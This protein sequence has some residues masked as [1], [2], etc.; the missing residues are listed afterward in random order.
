MLIIL[1]TRVTFP[2]SSCCLSFRL[3]YSLPF[4]FVCPFVLLPLYPSTVVNVAGTSQQLDPNGADVLG[5]NLPSFGE[6]FNAGSA[7]VFD[8]TYMD[9][10]LRI[11]RSKVGLVDQLRVFVRSSSSSASSNIATETAAAS[12]SSV[13]VTDA[14]ILAK[15]DENDVDDISPS[16]Y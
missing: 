5:I 2:P 16:D 1:R 6:F 11:S 7:D 10:T 3:S 12:S 9:E 4:R 13:A 15:D 14:D 8:T